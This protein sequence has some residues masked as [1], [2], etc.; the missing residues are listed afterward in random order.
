MIRM[1]HLQSAYGQLGRLCRGYTGPYPTLL[2][3]L[4]HRQVHLY[5][6]SGKD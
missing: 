6:W 4:I 3:I 5:H 2:R 1:A